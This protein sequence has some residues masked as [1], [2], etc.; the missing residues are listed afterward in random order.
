ME[1]VR[2]QLLRYPHICQSCSEYGG[3][4]LYNEA[5]DS[6]SVH[7]ACVFGRAKLKALNYLKYERY[8][9]V[10][11]RW[12]MAD[13][14]ACRHRQRVCGRGSCTSGDYDQHEHFNGR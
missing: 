2:S 14:D 3:A 7:V 5:V 9:L 13:D 8:V 12:R 4:C 1:T 10:Y 11:Q 6:M